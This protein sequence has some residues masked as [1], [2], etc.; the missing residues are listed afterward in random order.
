MDRQIFWQGPLHLRISIVRIR[1]GHV[2]LGN[3]HPY[4]QTLEVIDGV[5]LVKS[6]GLGQSPS[7]GEV[8]KIHTRVT[9]SHT[10]R[11]N[12]IDTVPT[13]GTLLAPGAHSQSLNT[14]DNYAQ[15]RRIRPPGEGESQATLR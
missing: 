15:N 1:L 6:R 12:D 4:G 13:P 7:A 9:P 2:A 10:L 5:G 14:R 3:Y 8:I 11:S